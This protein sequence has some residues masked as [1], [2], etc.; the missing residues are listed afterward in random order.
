[1]NKDHN[2]NFQEKM[3]SL[4]IEKENQ[5]S[6]GWCEQGRANLGQNG[7][8]TQR[9]EEEFKTQTYITDGNNG[10]FVS[11]HSNIPRG[12]GLTLLVLGNGRR[13]TENMVRIA[14]RGAENK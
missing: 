14:K 2:N 3:R 8:R 12:H 4:K 9:T 5:T 1:M 7:K 10:S 6:Q 13:R 11:F